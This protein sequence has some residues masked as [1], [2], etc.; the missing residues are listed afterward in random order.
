MPLP[1]QVDIDKIAA[2]VWACTTK[3]IAGWLKGAPR[4]ETA[5]VNRLTEQLVAIRRGCDVGLDQK[6]VVKSRVALLHR[7]GPGATDLFGG[8]L[9]VT[10]LA[11]PGDFVKTALFQ[12]KKGS[13]FKATL[14]R[15][16]LEDALKNRE[17]AGR[18]FVLYV[19]EERT[20]VRVNGV[21]D[22]LSKFKAEA[23]S[24]TTS[25]TD[26]MPLHTW[27]S[28]W[29]CCRVGLESEP[30]SPEAI[31]ATL[32]NHELPNHPAFSDSLEA[33]LHSAAWLIYG[34]APSVEAI[35]SH[36]LGELLQPP[37]ARRRG[38]K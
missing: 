18:S 5:F 20:G 17:A 16:Q 26:W 12:V 11:E 6:V 3:A 33:P 15:D 27:L 10:I 21:G 30:E 14:K 8:D 1:S 38:R 24:L 25:V 36:A 7:R 19:D 13:Q 37:A 23:D 34:M 29:L 31:E 32:A 28:E 22:V 9:A 35:A 2:T 4:D